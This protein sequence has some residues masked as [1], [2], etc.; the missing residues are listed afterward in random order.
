MFQF[1]D[2]LIHIIISFPLPEIIVPDNNDNKK[3]RERKEERRIKEERK[4]IGTI[5]SSDR[6]D[7]RKGERKSSLSARNINYPDECTFNYPC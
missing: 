2:S 6:S 3:K 5:R 4:V 7:R 1:K